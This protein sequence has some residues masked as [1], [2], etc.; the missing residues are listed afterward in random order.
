[1]ENTEYKYCMNIGIIVGERTDCENGDR[2]LQLN[3]HSLVAE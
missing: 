2:V 1:M 3:G